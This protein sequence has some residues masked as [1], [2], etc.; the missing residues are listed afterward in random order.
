MPFSLIE[1]QKFFKL[2]RN[3]ETVISKTNFQHNLDRYTTW[4]MFARDI[5][6]DSGSAY[7]TQNLYGVHPFYMCTE[8]D[9]KA[10]GVFILNSNAQQ[11]ETGPGP[12][13]LYR[14]IG[15]RIGMAFF[16]RP[17]K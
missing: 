1:K 16:Q 8:S 17:K 9:G 3:F 12:H 7:S 14:T 13:F 6:P 4:P 2:Y 15:G 10:R 5:G 11:V